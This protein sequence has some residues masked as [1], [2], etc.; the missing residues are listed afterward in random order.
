MSTDETRNDQQPTQEESAEQQEQPREAADQAEQAPEAEDRATPQEGSEGEV[1]EL[2]EQLAEQKEQ[3][4]RA[5]AE[6]QNVRR[7]SELD[8]QK[9]H[10]FGTEKLIKELLPVVD[11]LEKAIE[12]TRDDEV[13]NEKVVTRIRE[14]VDMTLNMLLTNLEKF[15]VKQ[16]N[17]VGE[18]FDPQLH[19]AMSMVPSQE[20]EP[21]SVIAVM[22]KGY[23]LNDRLVRPAMV[24][25]AKAPE[26]G[27]VDEKA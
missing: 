9:A 27:K 5:K 22:Q 10:K 6:M 4:L 14:G 24:M 7:R 16:I 3:V 26:G 2:R 11:S 13:A 1:A 15:N 12:S 19:E 20:A 18:P 8:V 17:P 23:T 21:N 25:V